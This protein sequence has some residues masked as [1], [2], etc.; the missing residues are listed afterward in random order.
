[1]KKKYLVV[2]EK[3]KNATGFSA[4]LPDLPGCV[5]TGRT[6]KDVERNIREAVALHIAGMKDDGEIPDDPQAFAENLEIRI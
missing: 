1:L 2:F 5:A 3:T 6:R 4:F